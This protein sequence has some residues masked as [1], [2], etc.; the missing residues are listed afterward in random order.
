MIKITEEPNKYAKQTCLGVVL[1][2]G[3]SSR[4][5]EDKAYLP[6]FSKANGN[7]LSFSKNLLLDSGLE[8]VVVSGEQHHVAD[9]FQALGPLSGIYSVIKKYQPNAVLVL[10]IDLPLLTKN[11]LQTLKR[12]GELSGKATF[13]NQH[14]LPL[15]LPVNAF[16][17][18]FL[19]QT[20]SDV[21]QLQNDNKHKN[22]SMRHLLKHVPHQ[23]LSLQNKQALLNCNSPDDW[24]KAKALYATPPL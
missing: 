4:M 10:P 23:A 5:G 8:Q 6:H 11:L 21:T 3:L 12:A 18:M 9:E 19:Q 14:F 24:Q 13:Y 20:F 16:T 7:M 17:D 15:Y 2:G 22:L 1:A